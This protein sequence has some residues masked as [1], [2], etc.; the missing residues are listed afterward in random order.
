MTISD[1]L[2]QARADLATLEADTPKLQAAQDAQATVLDTA[3]REARAGTA[4]LAAV[5]RAQGQHEAACGLLAQHRQD[6]ADAAAQVG[7]LERADRAAHL[8]SEGRE[9][10]RVMQEAAQ[11][12]ATRAAQAEEAVRLA[13]DELARLSAQHVQARA[14]LGAALRAQV[15]TAQ[16]GDPY[17]YPDRLS[18]MTDREAGRAYLGEIDP[19]LTE[20]AVLAPWGGELSVPEQRHPHLARAMRARV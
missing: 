9:A 17:R 16:G 20:P 10:Y 19:T 15:A 11:A 3:R 6:V 5:V 8:L 7:E 4:T 14:R 12:H 2:A 13:L 18:A 1:Q